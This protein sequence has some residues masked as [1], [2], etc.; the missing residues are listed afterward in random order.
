MGTVI[1]PV[2]PV[3]PTCFGSHA[4]TLCSPRRALCGRIPFCEDQPR[5][6]PKSSIP[7]AATVTR[8]LG[9][10]CYGSGRRSGN[11]EPPIDERRTRLGSGCRAVGIGRMGI[12]RGSSGR[13]RHSP[14]RSRRL[15]GWASAQLS[16]GPHHADR[17]R[18][19]QVVRLPRGSPWVPQPTQRA[20]RPA[21]NFVALLNSLFAVLLISALR[22]SVNNTRTKEH[23]IWGS[24][25]RMLTFSVSFG[26]QPYS[27]TLRAR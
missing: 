23:V 3:R 21:S 18:S 2:R 25:R 24:C 12:G 5:S 9:N 1:H 13:R 19:G 27:F 20:S 15:G 4:L 11:S 7:V 22:L 14:E 16:R 8:R 6:R 10:R 17:D 26:R